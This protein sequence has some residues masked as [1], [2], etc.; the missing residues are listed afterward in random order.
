[1]SAR[2]NPNIATSIAFP[3][4]K[5]KTPPNV[6]SLGETRLAGL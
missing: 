4:Q 1:M 6:I 2:A 5:Q 3:T